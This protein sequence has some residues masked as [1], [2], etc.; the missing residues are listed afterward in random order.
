MSAG[1]VV[2]VG[3]VV[4]IEVVVDVK[5]IVVGNEVVVSDEVVMDDVEVV[6]VVVVVD[7]LNSFPLSIQEPLDLQASHGIFSPGSNVPDS[8][9]HSLSQEYSQ[10]L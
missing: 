5:V 7:S 9:P 3:G 4:V 10:Y 1:M 2:V 8:D 6:V